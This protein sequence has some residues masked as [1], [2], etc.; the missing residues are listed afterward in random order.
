MAVS[1]LPTALLL[2]AVG[3]L[4]VMGFGVVRITGDS[5]R[6]AIRA[7][8]VAVYRRGL[9]VGTGDVIVYGATSSSRVVHRVTHVDGD[10]G[11]HT[12]GDA[13][14]IGDRDTLSVEAVEGRVVFTIPTGWVSRVDLPR[15][16]ATLLIRIEEWL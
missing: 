9:D 15:R 12:R 1:V 8:D 13:N 14:T 3:A 10:G 11:V 2:A 5:M 7:G 4:G 16:G 6:P